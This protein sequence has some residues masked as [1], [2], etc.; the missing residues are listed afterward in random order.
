MNKKHFKVHQ[1]SGHTIHVTCYEAEGNKKGN[2][3]LLHGMAENFERYDYFA[4]ILSKHSYSVY[5]YSHRGHGTNT[6]RNA[7]GF[8][9]PKNGY[10]LVIHDAINVLKSIKQLNP[11]TPLYLMGHSMGSLIT[12]NV[13]QTYQDL[14]GAIICAT[15][16]PSRFTTLAGLAMSELTGYRFAPK[17]ISPLMDKLMFHSKKYTD[18]NK[19]TNFDWIC[20]DEKEVDKYIANPYC[21]FLCSKS[22]YHDLLMITK[23]ATSPKKILQ[24]DPTLPI[25]IISGKK[26]PVG[27]YS[28]DIVR[29]IHFYE[30]HGYDITSKLYENLRHELL[31]EPKKDDITQDIINFLDHIN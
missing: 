22:F 24:T 27:G 25:M 29:L 28:K 26:D 1:K 12:R 21:G 5:L 7:L 19:R 10:R 4:S 14:D 16:N 18:L 23:N 3:L 13:I 30:R 8:F 31:N 9:A 20:T 11:N 2:L 17:Q 6:P 15:A